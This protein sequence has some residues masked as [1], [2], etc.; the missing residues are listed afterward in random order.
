[1]AN[2]E[3]FSANSLGA[4]T[5]IIS[6]YCPRVSEGLFLSPTTFTAIHSWRHLGCLRGSGGR[7]LRRLRSQ[8]L[9]VILSLLQPEA[10]NVQF[11][12]DALTD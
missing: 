6:L 4:L 1:M 9:H 8:R 2:L 5:T 11:D 12:D 3:L 7:R 10:R